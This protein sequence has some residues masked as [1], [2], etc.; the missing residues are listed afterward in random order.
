MK[1]KGGIVSI[2]T[3]AESREGPLQCVGKTLRR[4]VLSLQRICQ[5][6]SEYSRSTCCS[7]AS[8]KGWLVRKEEKIEE[9]KEEEAGRGATCNQHT[10]V[11]N[12]HNKEHR[13]MCK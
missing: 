7:K 4:T 2:V 8:Y 11:G 9:E 5:S 10:A 13:A 12:R 1:K 6:R 3:Y